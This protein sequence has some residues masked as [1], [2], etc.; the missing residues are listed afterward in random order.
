MQGNEA[1][2]YLSHSEIDFGKWDRCIENSVN[3]LPYA[4]S[5]YLD[6]VAHEKWDAFVIGDYA[7]VFPLPYKNRLLFK[8]FYQP[9]F[10]QQLGLFFTQQQYAERVNECITLARKKSPKIYMQLNTSNP[11]SGE[12]ISSRVT[13]HIPLQRSYADITNHYSGVVKKNLKSAGKKNLILT[14]KISV[15]ECVAFIRKNVGDK[16]SNMNEKDYND[17]FVL[18]ERC[19][20]E[21]KG[22]VKSVVTDNGNL[23]AVVFLLHSRGWYI[24]L[25]AAA[26][27]E[28]KKNNAMTWLIDSFMQEFA[29]QNAI[30]DFEGSSIPGIAQFFKSFGGEEKYFPVV[31]K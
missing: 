11:V 10:C 25:S 26:S 27:A 15:Q 2:Q 18:M 13:H 14:D 16:V 29:G 30:F 3:A 9:F 5:W 1:I 4:Y 12:N 8:Q 19:V 6:I 22:M 28:G 17:L 31:K 7:A 23:L 21:K 20:S 24:Y